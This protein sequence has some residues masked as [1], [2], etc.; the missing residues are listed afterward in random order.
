MPVQKQNLSISFEQGLDTKTDPFQVAPGKFLSLVNMVF[1]VDKRLTKRKGFD[2]LSSPA[3][4]PT[5]LTTYNA[6]LIGVGTRLSA[7]LQSDSAWIDQGRIQAMDLSTLPL[8]RNSKSQNS[9]DSVVSMGIACTTWVDSASLPFYQIQDSTTGQIVVAPTALPSGAKNPRVFVLG[10]YFI[11]TFTVLVTAT[12]T[13][14]YI[15]IPVVNP[16][17]PGSATTISSQVSSDAAAY[18]GCVVNNT[19]FISWDGSDIGGAIRTRYIQANLT[20]SSPV[21]EAGT[22]ATYISVTADSSPNS[23]V[24]WVTVLT[25]GT[26]LKSLAYSISL[27]AVLALTSLGAAAALVE[28][29]TV[30]DNGSLN[31]LWEASV[32]YSY[33]SR[34]SDPITLINITQAGVVGSGAIIKRGVGL[35]SK[36]FI[37]DGTQYFMVV[38]GSA[39]SGLLQPTYFLSDISGN[40]IAKLAYSNGGGYY[41]T[42]VLPSVTV[43]GSTAKIAYRFKDLIAAVN[44]A[45]LTP[46]S[47][48]SNIYS[49]TGINLATFD[50]SETGYA[51]A[52][53]G[54]NLHLSGGLLW[55]YDG[56]KP[57]EH[58]FLLFPEDVI[59]STSTTGGHLIDQ[60]YYYAATYEWTDSQGNLHRSAPSVPVKQTTTGG[61]TS[62]NTVNIPTLRLTYK[63]GDNLVRIVVYRWSTAQQTYYQVSSISSPTLNST[64]VNSVA[65]TDTLADTSIVGN[66]ILYTSGGVIEN[67]AAPASSIFA[68]YK[69]R[70]VL[71]DAENPNVLWYSKQVIQSVPVEMSDLL[72]IYVAPT[73][74]AQGD[75]GPTTALGAMDDK[76]IIFKHDAIYY[77]TGDGPDNTGANNDFSEPVFIT[78]TVGCSNPK[79]IVLMPNGLMFQSD[80]GIWLLGRDLSTSYIGADVQAFNIYDVTSALA[81][82]DTNQVRFTLSTGATLTYDYYYQ[83][84]AV[85]TLPEAVSAVIFGGYHTLLALEN[86]LFQES[87]TSYLDGSSPVL[88]SWVTGWINLAGIQGFQRV[89]QVQLLGEY[90]SPH[91]LQLEVGYDYQARTQSVMITPTNYSG[92][93]GSELYGGGSPYGGPSSREQFRIFT[94]QQKCQAFQVA[95]REVYDSSLEAQ[96]GEGLTLSGFNLVVGLKKGYVPL[97][98]AQS[99]G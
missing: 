52:E 18:D 9:V 74:G 67:I 7:L 33:I 40:I 37:V 63:T 21:T 84:W 5:I 91:K 94:T 66:N 54:E 78:A 62:T 8:V 70:L 11:V 57:V 99:Y 88:M 12:P 22:A 41:T 58:S 83:Q 45:N 15:A 25:G 34:R 31:V 46:P 97:P 98:A 59:V 30:A 10:R 53:I 2:L 36:A 20:Q 27:N 85:F 95:L 60:D 3:S 80:K 87:A 28:L 73:A 38:Y 55:M 75:T 89:S 35:A 69:S 14:R 13:L 64:S 29:T 16:T 49:Q 17:V 92:P 96:A 56:V 43:S 77:E 79:S 42:F 6:N 50:F 32:D 39:N 23:P 19:L 51:T 65:F 26:T 72:T 90:K 48:S 24:I 68:L 1:N 44:P 82:P 93:Y 86:R 71:V 47:T 61:T 76:L 81:I 4:A